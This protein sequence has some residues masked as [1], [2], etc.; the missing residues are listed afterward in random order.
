MARLIWNDAGN[1]RFRAG[2]DRGVLYIPG[3]VGVP[4]NGLVSVEE[5]S[6]GGESKAYYFDGIKYA[7]GIDSDEF[8]GTLEAFMWPNEFNLVD[9]NVVL[10]P[11]LF[12]RNQP[13]NRFGLSWRTLI[14]DDLVG[15]DR[16]YE[17]HLLYNVTAD[18]TSKKATTLGATAD[19]ENF[20]WT[21]NAV[22]PAATTYKPTAHFVIDSTQVSPT[23]LA[24][25]EDRLYGRTGANSFLPPQDIVISML[26]S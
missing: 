26:S 17:L 21:L 8:Q 10:A 6:V 25:L 13:R 18:P 19:P 3:A 23:A 9:G 7:H 1:R 15:T 22:A 11:G 16:G 12:A 24:T 4:W 5:N 2:V 20:Q 14:G